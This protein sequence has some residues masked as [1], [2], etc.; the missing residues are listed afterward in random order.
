MWKVCY[1]ALP[2]KMNLVRRKI[3]E[4][5]RCQ[6]C[7]V[8]PESTYKVEF[9]Q[10]FCWFYFV[11]NLLVIQ[12]LETLYL[13]GNHVRVVYERVWRKTQKCAFCRDSRLD[14]ASDS[15]LDLTSDSR[16]ASRQKRHTCEACRGAEESRQLLHYKTK[17]PS[18]PGSLLAAWTCNS[19]KSRGQV[20]KPV[21]LG[22]T[23]LSHSKHTLV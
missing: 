7:D 9:N 17:V 8:L 2:T 12:H 20:T 3:L 19:V 5:D 23:D 15:R 18:W 4:I 16:L 1:N 11:P 6:L 10:P 13:C 22:K 14:L 21:C